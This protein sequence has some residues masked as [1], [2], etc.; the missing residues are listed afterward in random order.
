MAVAS[1][2]L[3]LKFVC[4]YESHK[5]TTL[6]TGRNFAVSLPPF[7]ET[8]PRSLPYGRRRNPSLSA[9][10]SLLASLWLPTTGVTCY[11]APH[12]STGMSGLS[13]PLSHSVKGRPSN[14]SIM[15]Q[16]PKE[17]KYDLSMKIN[18]GQV[19]DAR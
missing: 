16:L 7:D 9:S 8:I 12:L 15:Q 1:H 3:R 6:H 2:L 10:A 11:L 4:S 18:V 17:S 5:S 14:L 13:S 19:A